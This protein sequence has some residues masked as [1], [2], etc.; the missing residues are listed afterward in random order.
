MPSADELA[1]LSEKISDY[2]D[3]NFDN[4]GADFTKEALKM[5]YGVAEQRNIRGHST[6]AEEK[7]LQEEGIPFFKFPIK[8]GEDGA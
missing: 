4:V 3:K 1:A 8:D 7:I 6:S 2:I 5:H